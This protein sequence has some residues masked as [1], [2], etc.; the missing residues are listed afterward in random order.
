MKLLLLLAPVALLLAQTR[1]P[2][3]ENEFVRVVFAADRPV[4][5]AGPLHEHKNNRVMIYLDS[6]D[7][8]I[9]YADGKVENQHW[10]TGD[11]AWSPANGMHTS[12]NISA[13]PV[14]IIEIELKNAGTDKA[15]Q[16]TRPNFIMDNRQVRVYRGTE[17]P[18]A[19]HYLAADVKAGTA[20]WDKMPEGAGP[21]VITEIK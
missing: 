5:Q 7:I 11:V 1:T 17:A 12:Q 6:G 19:G 4:A 9:K 15:E 21:F 3:I 2:P 10:K 20:F 18:N 8:Q 16:T 13:Q 14:R